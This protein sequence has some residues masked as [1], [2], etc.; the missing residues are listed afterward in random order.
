MAIDEYGALVK[1]K[2]TP[3]T[4]RK[5]LYSCEMSRLPYFVDGSQ[6]VVRLQPYATAAPL[7][8]GRFLVFIFV[9]D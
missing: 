7:P 9:R 5:G 3:V 2:A 8:P 6:I 4:G 1:G